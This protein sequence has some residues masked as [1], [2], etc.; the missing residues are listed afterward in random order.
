M[1]LYTADRETG[2]FIEEIE[3]IAE[4]LALI[5]EYEA[6]DKKDGTYTEDFYDIVNESHESVEK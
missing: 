3:S 4:G 5:A 2:T 1:K 6:Q